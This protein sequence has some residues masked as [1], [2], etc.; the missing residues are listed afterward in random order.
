MSAKPAWNPFDPST[1]AVCQAGVVRDVLA[2]FESVFVPHPFGT[3]EDNIRWHHADL[4]TLADLDL[5]REY[6]RARWLL[7]WS[8][9]ADPWIAERIKAVRAEEE[10][11]KGATRG[12]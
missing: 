7:A 9:D 3:H 1:W 2:A 4:A 8:D 5:L 10:R 6:D 11:R 12:R